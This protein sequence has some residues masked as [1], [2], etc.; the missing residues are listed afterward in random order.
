[1]PLETGDQIGDLVPA[2]P[3]GT[4]PKSEGD[5]H[6][7]L[8]KE[9][10]QGSLGLMDELLAFRDNNVPLRMRNAANDA[11]L[12]LIKINGA[13]EIELPNATVVV[14]N[15]VRIGGAVVSSIG[16]NVGQFQFSPTTGEPSIHNNGLNTTF[17]A[18][19]Q[20]IQG[21]LSV[22]GQIEAPGGLNGNITGNAATADAAVA[23]GFVTLAAQPA[24]QSV[25]TLDTLTV[26]GGLNAG[27]I[28][29]TGNLSGLNIFGTIQTAAQPLIT[30]VGV[31]SSLALSGPTNTTGITSATTVAYGMINSGN[32]WFSASANNVG[33]SVASVARITCTPT[34]YVSSLAPTFT[35]LAGVGTRAVMVDANGLLSAPP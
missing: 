23:A 4:D 25:G 9:C 18:T 15:N 24:I 19:G 29:A 5:N 34:T 30:S 17:T 11:Y 3:F 13:D 7:R 8:I 28:T 31:L 35:V 2:N 21:E 32:G 20:V 27:S 1:M 26:A 10:V 6:L 14:N 16:P 22:G 33:L 12:D